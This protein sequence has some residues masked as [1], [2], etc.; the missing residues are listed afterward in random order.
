MKCI[1]MTL[2]ALCAVIFLI[3][4]SGSLASAQSPG[5]ANRLC[6]ADIDKFCKG[7]APGNGRIAKCLN[8][9]ASELSPECKAN[10]IELK[11]KITEM[12]ENCKADV[13]KFCKDV[14]PGAGRIIKCLKTHEAEL[15]PACRAD[16]TRPW[17]P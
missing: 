14:N 7:M 4:I 17:K 15:D 5:K 10:R 9:H 2:T 8:E 1:S 6:M 13:D 3:S 11:K 16:I 12:R